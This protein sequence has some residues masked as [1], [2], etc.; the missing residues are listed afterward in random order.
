[1]RWPEQLLSLWEDWLSRG[2]YEKRGRSSYVLRDQKAVL[3]LRNM[4]LTMHH[5]GFTPAKLSHLH[6]T[7]PVGNL[8][9]DGCIS[10]ISAGNVTWR[11]VDACRGL[12]ADLVYLR[13]LG[14]GRIICRF[15][16]VRIHKVRASIILPLLDLEEGIVNESLRADT[17]RE[18]GYRLDRRFDN[19]AGTRRMNDW[20]HLIHTEDQMS[21]AMIALR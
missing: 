6:R 20:A 2:V 1:M 12:I 9:A 14:L 13:E 17:V 8:P 18:L 15:D 21:S 19:H 5:A 4:S 11:R 7:Y 16:E 3:D 10:A